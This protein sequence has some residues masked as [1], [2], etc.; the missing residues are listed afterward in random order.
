MI[1]KHKKINFKQK[2]ILKFYKT[3]FSPHK[4][5]HG[6]ENTLPILWRVPMH[7][8]SNEWDWTEGCHNAWVE[9]LYKS[10]TLLNETLLVDFES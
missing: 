1:Q 4:Q 5:H 8:L 3:W 7:D 10:G 2:I 6:I 9:N